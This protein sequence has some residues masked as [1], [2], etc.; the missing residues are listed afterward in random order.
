VTSNGDVLQWGVGFSTGD[1]KP[2]KTLKGKNIV[3]LALTR[4]K[5]YALSKS[6]SV[7]V[8]ASSS[9]DQR[10]YPEL[11]K[12][13]WYAFWRTNPGVSVLD[14]RPQQGS[15]RFVDIAVG[16]SHLLA[17]SSGGKV[18][19]HP[20]DLAANFNGQLGLRNV[21]TSL[22][23]QTLHP[24][25]FEPDAVTTARVA[26][27]A[28]L[29]HSEYYPKS[30]VD[31]APTPAAEEEALPV[32]GPSQ[33]VKSEQEMDILFCKELYPIPS[34]KQIKI[35]QIA[36]GGKHSIV[37]TAEGRVLGFGSNSCSSVSCFSTLAEFSM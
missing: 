29:A 19:S 20:V 1:R 6:G 9:N 10:K 13:P 24:S 11:A 22:G 3:K 4:D 28:G 21:N 37:K 7:Y 18:Y 8:F 30:W 34:L 31:G 27:K 5:V 35:S 17:Q 33:R 32:A 26:P 36:A 14:L 23:P 25:G 16:E 12:E 2:K 15:E